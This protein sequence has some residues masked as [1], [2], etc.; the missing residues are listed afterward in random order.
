LM[1][2]DFRLLIFD[3]ERIGKIPGDE[4]LTHELAVGGAWRRGIESH[5]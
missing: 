3:L 2:G 1:I 5:R 4:S